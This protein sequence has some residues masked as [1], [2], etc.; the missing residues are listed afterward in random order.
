MSIGNKKQL[1]EYLY[2]FAVDGGGSASNI[3]L[4]DKA[5]SAPL[6]VGA[7][8]TG[9]TAHCLTNIAGSSS[10]LEWGNSDTDGYSGT[11]IAEATFTENYVMDHAT[12]GGALLWDDSNDHMIPYRVAD[13]AT[14]AFNF[15]INVADLTAG[16]IRFFVEYIMPS[17]V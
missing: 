12:V 1:Q 6:P 15:L 3:V 5:G 7:I 8:V 17:E 14:G 4:S 11:A 10:T 13:A 16:K 9:V 2:D